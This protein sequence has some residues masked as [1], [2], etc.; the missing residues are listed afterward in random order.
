MFG[1]DLWR[2]K[3]KKLRV[4]V[5]PCEKKAFPLPSSVFQVLVAALLLHAA[6]EYTLSLAEAARYVKWQ[7]LQL[8]PQAKT[9]AI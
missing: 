8:H 1:I 4:S 9:R 2:T 7:L 3:I 5:S 6:S